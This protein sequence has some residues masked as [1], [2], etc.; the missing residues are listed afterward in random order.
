MDRMKKI[1][2]LI[3]REVSMIIRREFQDPR[4]MF[5]TVLRVDVSR[6]LQH[7]DVYYSVLG[8]PEKI[9]AVARILDKLCGHIRKLI[10]QRIRLRTI[11]QV[12]FLYD[13]SIERSAHMEQTF[14]E[15]NSEPTGAMPESPEPGRQE[16]P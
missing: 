11:P 5:M 3:K 1:N 15:I 6:D 12:R 8:D 16:Q 9:E 7:A 4:L 14:R 13:Q 2:Q 10:G